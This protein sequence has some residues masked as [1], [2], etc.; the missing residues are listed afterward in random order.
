MTK[1]ALFPMSLLVFQNIM[2]DLGYEMV[3][4]N[5]KQD[6]VI[7][8]QR[9]DSLWPNNKTPVTI[10]LPDCLDEKGIQQVYEKDFILDFFNQIVVDSNGNAQGTARQSL[11]K[12]IAKRN[13][14]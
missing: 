14:H 9:P 5:A 4:L 8:R 2:T 10:S 1:I 13:L 12:I 6:G 3:S 11:A 7:F